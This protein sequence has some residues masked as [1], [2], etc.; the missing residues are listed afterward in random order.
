MAIAL[1]PKIS[2]AQDMGWTGMN[3]LPKLQYL[4]NCF[5][6]LSNGVTVKYSGNNNY[7]HI[8]R[9]L[10]W[11]LFTPGACTV[12]QCQTNKVCFP[13]KR[14]GDVLLNKT[15]LSNQRIEAPRNIRI[16]WPISSEKWDRASSDIWSRWRCKISHPRWHCNPFKRNFL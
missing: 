1:G 15:C 14:P 2:S 5:R 3:K 16:R 8:K 13:A 6:D 9:S 7:N 10:A 4:G 11:T 12:G